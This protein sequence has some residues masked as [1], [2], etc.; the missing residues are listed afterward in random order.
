LKRG[1]GHDDVHRLER[2][3]ELR[4]AEE[5]KLLQRKLVQKSLLETS[6]GAPPISGF[7][8]L[9]RVHVSLRAKTLEGRGDYYARL[10]VE[11]SA[12][13]IHWTPRDGHEFAEPG[14]NFGTIELPQ[15]FLR[16]SLVA[17]CDL[18]EADIVIALPWVTRA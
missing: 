17:Q 14:Q 11:D 2:D 18:L 13:G 4:L 3:R 5:V 8:E 10:L 16:G 7:G 15:D 9:A 6:Y 12:D 1:T